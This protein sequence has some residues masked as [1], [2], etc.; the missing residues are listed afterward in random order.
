MIVVKGRLGDQELI[1]LAKQL[2]RTYRDD[3]MQI[4]DDASGIKAY[5]NWTKNY[6]SSAYPYP[7]KWLKKHHLGMI[8]KMLARGGA[9]W[10]LFGGS[11]H[12]TSPE[13]EIADLD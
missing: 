9:K 6:P 13:S 12:P 5:E 11:A 3:S 7:E 10:Q 8:N 1:E 2:H 4:F